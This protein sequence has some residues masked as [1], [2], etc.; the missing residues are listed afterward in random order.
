MKCFYKEA[1]ENLL[2]PLCMPIL[3]SRQGVSESQ[4]ARSVVLH[5]KSCGQ[6]A[7][8]AVLMLTPIR[9][10]MMRH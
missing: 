10:Q 8:F 5:S 7:A 1:I 3:P 9:K 2:A 4:Y 6:A